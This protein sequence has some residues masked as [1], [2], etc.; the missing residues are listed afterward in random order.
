M[1][2][3]T[4][5][6]KRL[7]L[8]T[9][10]LFI[11]FGSIALAQQNNS[12][13]IS[14]SSS[15]IKIKN[16]NGFSGFH[17]R[18][19]RGDLF[20]R[21]DYRFQSNQ[22]RT[23]FRED[24]K[25][26]AFSGEINLFTNSY[27]FHP[28]FIL[29]DFNLGYA[30]GVQKDNFLVAPDR[31]DSRSAEKVNLALTLFK[32]RPVSLKTFANYNHSFINREL[33]TD[34]ESYQLNAGANLF[35]RNDFLPVTVNYN[36]SNWIQ[37]ELQSLRTFNSKRNNFSVQILKNISDWNKNEFEAYYEEYFRSYVNTFVNNKTTSYKL[38]N[39][40]FF[41]DITNQDDEKEVINKGNDR[42]TSRILYYNQVGSQP[43]RRFIINQDI[44]IKSPSN[45]ELDA[46]YQYSDF[47]HL[48]TTSKQHYG[49]GQL[50]HQ[51]YKSLR[52]FI[53]F[54]YNKNDQSTFNHNRELSG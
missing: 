26:G 16:G 53:N 47:K 34:V 54:E 31:T 46:R 24:Q 30:P 9:T 36:Y 38:T 41:N 45:I 19:I 29:I 28:N 20:L 3:K 11:Y 13:N 42:Y 15:K 23:G 33:T 25:S 1:F 27:L 14:Y 44:L 10:V 12:S 17:L 52:T 8:I 48:V 32:R 49:F 39:K 4:L 6:I 22:L 5:N 51:L 50:S 2:F 43:I 35:L 21:G 40:F 37:D 18:S 7:L